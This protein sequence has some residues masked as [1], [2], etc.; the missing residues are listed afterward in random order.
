MDL[1]ATMLVM[2]AVGL[3]A[4]LL[5]FPGWLGMFFFWRPSRW[6]FLAAEALFLIA[7]VLYGPSVAHG[8][9]SVLDRASHVLAGAILAM[10]FLTPLRERFARRP[11]LG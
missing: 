4:V 11:A 8:V 1:S 10:A 3:L 2:V 9:E 6:L 5:W 7:V